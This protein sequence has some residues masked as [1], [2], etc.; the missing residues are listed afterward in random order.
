MKKFLSILLAIML[1]L[2][3]TP[4]FAESE[5]PTTGS[6]TEDNPWVVYSWSALKEKMALGGNIKLGED[7]VDPVHNRDSGLSVP[8]GKTVTLDLNGF[9][10]DRNME[11]RTRNGY[12]IYVSGT[13]NLYD[14]GETGKITGGYSSQYSDSGTIYTGGGFCVMGGTLNMYGGEVTENNASNYG[15]GGGVFVTEGGTFNMH[16]GKI[17]NNSSYNPGGGVCLRNGGTFTMNG[18]EISKNS[19]GSNGGGVSIYGSGNSFVMNDGVISE[20][21][22]GSGGGV[23][24][25]EGSSFIMNGGSITKNTTH[26]D[27]Y[28]SGFGAGVYSSGSFVMTGGSITENIASYQTGG[29]L[30]RNPRGVGVTIGGTCTIS[31]NVVIAGNKKEK[32]IYNYNYTEYTTEY[33][34][35][36][37]YLSNQYTDRIITIAD[38]LTDGASIGIDSEKVPDA[39]NPIAFTEGFKTYHENDEPSEFFFSDD[40]YEV[41]MLGDEAALY[42]HTHTMT[43]VAE[44]AADC[45]TA[46]KE[47]YYHCSG[48]GKDFEDENGNTVIADID[49]WGII[50]ALDHDYSAQSTEDKYLKTA[51]T[52]KNVAE[53]YYSC[54]R[55]GEADPVNSFEY[56]TLALHQLTKVDEVQA[57][58]LNGGKSAYY[59]CDVC[60]KY[61]EEE[62]GTTEIADIVGYGITAPLGHDFGDNEKVC[63][64]C[65]VANPNYKEPAPVLTPEEAAMPTEEKTEEL[66][67]KTNTDKKDVS[68]S[69]YAPLKLKATTKKTNITVS[70]KTVS[71]ADGYIIYAAPCG[72]KLERAAT[73]ANPKAVKYTFKKLKKGKYYKYIVVAY[74]K[75]AAGNRIMSKSKSVHCATP[76]GKKGNPTG[77]KLKKAKITL[78]KGKKTKIKAT[79]LSKGKVATHIAKF[80]YES[81][82][83]KIATVDSKGNIKAKKK[84][85]VTIYVYAQ[86][87]LCRTIKVKV[88]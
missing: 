33:S 23:S 55:C 19:A 10:V 40:G 87:G 14:S 56:G 34:E 48:C 22:S 82:N 61:Y 69:A 71:G 57:D 60:G 36:N 77:I 79:L 74:K 42:L 1:L 51:A 50:D 64:R 88:K 52:C 35:S 25:G 76:G 45:V 80:R 11:S 30:P 16:G 63:K 26:A 24:Q 13:L 20:N 18:G 3:A 15:T 21:S 70:W 68:G 81:S 47:A 37:M 43:P 27:D 41:K 38:E 54:S 31:G 84:G 44:V 12:V 75:T 78:K 46:G 49:T 67:K 83:K 59:V 32:K 8:Y 53:Y 72:N 62:T 6:G 58:C 17:T 4:V 85:T 86:N 5:T 28:N 7:A 65:N 2:S 9:T 73:V 66:I 29:Y 39:E